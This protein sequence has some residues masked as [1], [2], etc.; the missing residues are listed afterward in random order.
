MTEFFWGVIASLS[1]V[2]GLFFLRF[3]RTSR[4]RFFLLFGIA[5]WVFALNWGGLALVNPPN[6]TRHYFHM[7][8]LV[9]FVVIIGAII[10]K[11]RKLPGR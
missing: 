4:D 6:E 7:V 9:A 3:W 5:F 1:F 10:D 8:R 2:T 11:N